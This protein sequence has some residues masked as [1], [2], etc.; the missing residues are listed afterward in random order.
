MLIHVFWDILRSG[1]DASKLLV[2]NSVNEEPRNATIMGDDLVFFVGQDQVYWSSGK[3]VKHLSKDDPKVSSSV[4]WSLLLRCET[5]DTTNGMLREMVT[6]E[7]GI[8]LEPVPFFLTEEGFEAQAA[9]RS[10]KM[11]RQ[12]TT[13]AVKVGIDSDTITVIIPFTEATR[14]AF[15]Q[16]IKGLVV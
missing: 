6:K 15:L 13:G 2:E 10:C 9:H 12:R 16:R 14:Q 7:S 11:E 3:L 8:V 5:S 4:M 1:D